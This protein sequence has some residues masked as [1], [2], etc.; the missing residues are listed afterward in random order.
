[1]KVALTS[2]EQPA[3]TA[4]KVPLGSALGGPLDIT[5]ASPAQAPL[6]AA[7][8][9]SETRAGILLGVSSMFLMAGGIVMAKPVL[10]ISSVW[11]ATP[12]RLLGGLLVLG[13]HALSPR[14]RLAVWRAFVSGRSWVYTVPSTLLGSYLALVIWIAG[15]KLAR[16]GVAGVLNQLS[17]LLVP[18]LAAIVLK[19]KLTGRKAAAVVLGF[20]GALLATW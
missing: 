20:C 13:V 11:W 17:T 14:H 6:F 3:V 2:D 8:E 16:A 7:G 5:P 15:M 9:R 18:L 4:V 19:E 1:V 10:N 12:V